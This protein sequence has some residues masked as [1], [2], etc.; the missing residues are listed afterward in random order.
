[1]IVVDAS[2]AFKWL[3]EE[4]GSRD[5]AAFASRSDLIAPS[6]LR[7][8]VA[9][10]LWKKSLRGEIEGGTAIAALAALDDFV[11][12]WVELAELTMPAFAIARE[13][14]HPV[15]DCYYLALAEQRDAGL[16]TADLR[17]RERCQRTRFAKI[18]V[19]WAP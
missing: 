16:A 9:N 6:L 1:L 13:L 3:V 19:D 18:L 17:L 10:A 8:E 2:L 4:E 11:K 5:A 7:A 15:Y 14:G 12:K